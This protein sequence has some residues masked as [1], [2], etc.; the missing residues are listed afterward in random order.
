MVDINREHLFILTLI[1][2]ILIK[3]WLYQGNEREREREGK[4]ENGSN[5]FAR[6]VTMVMLKYIH[7]SHRWKE[8]HTF[9]FSHLSALSLVYKLLS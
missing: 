8:E 7:L 3:K 1:L 6:C 4:R 9:T 5:S 2:S